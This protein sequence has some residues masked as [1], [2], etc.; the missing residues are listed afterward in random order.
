MGFYTACL[1]SLSSVGMKVTS[2]NQS[3][4][5]GQIT[6]CFFFVFFREFLENLLRVFFQRQEFFLHYGKTFLIKNHAYIVRE[7]Y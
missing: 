1:K 3:Q 7:G 4:V 2:E 5:P 6:I